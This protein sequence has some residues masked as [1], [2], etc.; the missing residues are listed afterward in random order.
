MLWR[1]SLIKHFLREMRDARVKTYE[2]ETFSLLSP[3]MASTSF[4][5]VLNWGIDTEITPKGKECGR[6]YE[7]VRESKMKP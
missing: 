4:S 2:A 6:S 3:L 5:V 7:T 1:A